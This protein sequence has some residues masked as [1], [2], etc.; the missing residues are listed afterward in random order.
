M[1]SIKIEGQVRKTTG[2]RNAKDLRNENQVPCV[3]YGGKETI[4]FSA[5][6]KTLKPLIYTPDFNVAAIEL[7]GKTVNAVIK[8][9][10]F[11]PITDLVSHIDFMELV[12]GKKI[13]LDIPVKLV[14]TSKGVREGGKMIQKMRK[15]KVKLTPENLVG[16][17]DVNVADLGLGKSIRVGDLSYNGIEIL[18]APNIPVCAAIIPRV[19]KEET[20][21]AAAPA[22]A[23]A[24]PAAAPAAAAKAPEKKK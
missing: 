12:P 6:R 13:I 15:L 23:A 11:H 9:I 1:N 20:T 21:T 8:E 2:Q 14:G 7:D 17:L 22:A 16:H 3:V 18:T 10:Q 24:A 5:T 19:V 4:S